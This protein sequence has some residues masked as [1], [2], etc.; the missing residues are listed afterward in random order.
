MNKNG[1][2]GGIIFVGMGLLS[3]FIYIF[4]DFETTTTSFLVSLI[5]SII[6]CIIGAIFLLM[7]FVREQRVLIFD[8]ALIIWPAIL[9]LAFWL[10]FFINMNFF[11]PFFM[12]GAFL[13]GLVLYE[14]Y[15]WTQ[16][17]N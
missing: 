5:G 2:I 14:I 10:F 13:M 3:I 15:L 4:F 1:L 9:G 8:R 12:L 6:I 7:A 17:K 11:P 16:D